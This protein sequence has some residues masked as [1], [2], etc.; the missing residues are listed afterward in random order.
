M[1]KHMFSGR[2]G[3]GNLPVISYRADGYPHQLK[4]N[5]ERTDPPKKL[6]SPGV[7]ITT[8]PSCC[9]TG[10]AVSCGLTCIGD[11]RITCGGLYQRG[12]WGQVGGSLYVFLYM[13][14]CVC[15]FLFM[16]HT[17]QQDHTV[18]LVCG[19]SRLKIGPATG[20]RHEQTA[21]RGGEKRRV[22]GKN[23]GDC[24]CCACSQQPG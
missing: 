5:K 21:E 7:W 2:E 12:A 23:S 20:G 6:S 18:L 3:G 15:V 16:T 11:I 4:E 24:K 10:R 9:V 17:M 22:A 14:V 8:M 1:C 13:C 19:I